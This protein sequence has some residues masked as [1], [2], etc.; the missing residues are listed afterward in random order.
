MGDRITTLWLFDGAAASA[1]VASSEP[2]WGT[3]ESAFS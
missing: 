1:G 2:L 3:V